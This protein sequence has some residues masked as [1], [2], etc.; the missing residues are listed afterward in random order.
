MS[1]YPAIYAVA[2]GY[3]DRIDYSVLVGTNL[4]YG[5]DIAFAKDGCQVYVFAYSI[6]P[7]VHPSDL[8]FYRP[9][10][11]VSVGQHVRKGDVIAYMYL[12]PAAGV[13]ELGIAPAG[14]GS[15][16]HFHIQ[17]KNTSLFLAPAIF[18]EALV[19]SFHARW[20][21]FGNDGSVPMPS[22]MGYKL[23]ADENPYG[24]ATEVLK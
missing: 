19:D 21:E 3:V 16:I 17:P 5:V 24:F 20:G 14:I 13:P 22:C 1:N 10:I 15:H 18:T 12:P 9:F 23:D 6:E 2:D 8:N 11:L 7:F 4:R